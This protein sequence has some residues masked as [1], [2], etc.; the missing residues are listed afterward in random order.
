MN[1][2]TLFISKNE[3]S[4]LSKEF[5][6]R[7]ST[8]REQI[9]KD[10]SN[11][12]EANNDLR[13]NST[14]DELLRMQEMNEVRIREIN[15]IFMTHKVIPHEEKGNS[16]KIT[17]IGSKVIVG[18]LPSSDLHTYMLVSE[19]EADPFKNKISVQSPIGI[20]LLEKKVG[21][22]FKYND[23]VYQILQIL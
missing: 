9:A 4:K 8:V 15:W 3:Y 7:T 18:I 13:E 10:L 5:E 14:Y 2:N 22:R 19:V 23:C 21:Y 20:N 12:F 1:Q 6:F 16:H 11:S 17:K